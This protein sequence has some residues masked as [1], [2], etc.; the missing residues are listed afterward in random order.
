MVAW[1]WIMLLLLVDTGYY[2]SHHIEG[3]EILG[4]TYRM[5]LCQQPCH[6]EIMSHYALVGKDGMKIV[7]HI[8]QT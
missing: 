3:A 6:D 2:Y 5:G 7:I 8:W 1:D 4:S